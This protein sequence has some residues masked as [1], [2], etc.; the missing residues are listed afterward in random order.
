[1]KK[2]FKIIEKYYDAI[3]FVLYGGKKLTPSEFG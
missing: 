1:M 2:L 3:S